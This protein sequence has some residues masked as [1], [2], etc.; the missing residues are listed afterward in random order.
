MAYPLL[1]FRHGLLVLCLVGAI[2]PG[3]PW[4]AGPEYGFVGAALAQDDD[5]GGNDDDGG[6]D[7]DGGASSPTRDDRPRAEGSDR[8]PA[9]GPRRANGPVSAA[10]SPQRPDRAADEVVVTGLSDADLAVLVQEGFTLRQTL[11][12]ARSGPRMHR[13]AI[14]ADLS[15]TD[16]RDRVRGLA[17]GRNAD[18]NHYYR[19]SESF[20]PA[21]SPPAVRQSPANTC[22]HL[23]CDALA[24]VDWPQ[25]RPDEC[26]VTIP[27]G[28]ID[29]GVNIDHS[30]LAG[31]EVELLRLLDDSLPSSAESHGTAVVALLAGS[32]GRAPGLLP[33]ARI[34]AIDI[35]SDAAGD[36][37]ADVVHLVQAIDL[38]LQRGI[39]IANLSLAG[40]EN[41]VLSDM[42]RTASDEGMLIVAAA[43]ND[44]PRAEPAWPA[45]A[46]TALAVTAVDGNGSIYRRAQRGAHLD[47]AAPGV[48]VWSAAS[49]RGVKPRTGTS[50][51]APFATAAAAVL[52]SQDQS[53]TPADLRARLGR[54]TRD[55]GAEGP[56]ELFGNG[57]LTL[58]ELC[59]PAAR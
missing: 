26:R 24:L 45:A 49:V 28:V 43:G 55:A 46:E 2:A 59:K 23:N 3:G 42:L 7:D 29:T 40:P 22:A 25:A 15:L 6:D 38:L 51:A 54:L 52:L 48:D 50:Y 27:I 20:V 12:L 5:D 14:P 35:F 32:E 41:R 47:I 8:S 9:N 34:L 56:D 36:E 10:G 21:A 1:S 19:T 13:L 17:S 18:F 4:P 31:A 58:T 33:E 39:R 16:A 30:A 11:N 44:G 37:R 53:L 57:I